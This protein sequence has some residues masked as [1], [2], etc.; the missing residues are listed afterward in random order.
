MKGVLVREKVYFERPRVEHIRD[1]GFHAAD[2]H[3]H[4]NHSDAYTTVRSALS[5]AKRKGVGLAITDHNTASGALEAFRM[6]TG[7][8]VIPGMEVSSEDGPHILL[9]FYDLGEMVEFY[10]REIEKRK[11]KSPYLATT[12]STEDLLECTSRYNC[13]RAAPHPY[14]YLVFNRGVAKCVEKGYLG[15]E[16]LSRLEAI[17]VIN[18][19]MTRNLNRRASDLADKLGLGLVGGTDGHIMRDLGNVLTCAESDDVEGFLSDIEHR[20]TFVVGREKNLIDKGLTAALLMTR[21][22]PYTV[23]SL[24]VHYRQNLPRVQRF[25]RG[26]AKRSPRPRTRAK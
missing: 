1:S 15:Q 6:Q 14:G 25:L 22:I 19:G 2:M 7:V 3:F 5:L 9:F 18:G 24:A 21:Y 8:L 23:P 17:E 10:H 16:T 20:R 13:V 12:L 11:G 26:R 4:T